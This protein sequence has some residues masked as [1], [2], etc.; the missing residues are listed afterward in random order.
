MRFQFGNIRKKIHVQ[1]RHRVQP[2]KIQ[3][4]HA[5]VNAID[6]PVV[7][8]RDAERAA[9]AHA[10]AEH[11]PRVADIVAIRPGDAQHV[12]EVLGLVLPE[13]KRDG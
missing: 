10:F 7:K 3:P 12:A 5:Q 2:Q 9:I 6:G 11:F 4:R 8:A 1:R 13:A